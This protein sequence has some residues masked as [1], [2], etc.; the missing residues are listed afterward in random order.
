MENP[1]DPYLAETPLLNF[2][3]LSL[4]ALIQDRQWLSLPEEARVG[5]I[6]GFVQNEIAF[7]YNTADDISAS[8]VLR[9]GYGQCNT[10]GTLLMALLRACGVRCR[11]HGFTIAKPLQ[12][13]AIT[14][15]AYQ[16]A[17]RNIVHSWVEVEVNGQW[18]NLEG[19]ILDQAYLRSLQ[20]RFAS[21]EGAFCGFGAATPNLEDPAVE[22]KGT[23]TYIQKDGINHDFGV[24]DSPDL[25]YAAHGS[26]L[27]GL[28][29]FLFLRYFRHQM[30]ANVAKVRR[31][32]W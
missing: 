30:N 28:K 32:Q 11:F 26:N 23:S 21:Q 2:S 22:W 16:L 8:E 6:Y 7:G 4:T 12:R 27:S 14:G 31:G 13:G 10:K 1:M 18:I 5:A 24:F 15:I 29:R 9:D 25:F 3:H 17:P 19:F 20:T